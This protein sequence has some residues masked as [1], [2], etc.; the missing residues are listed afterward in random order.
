MKH[1]LYLQQIKE[2]ESERTSL[3]G[4]MKDDADK[5]ASTPTDTVPNFLSYMKDG[6]ENEMASPSILSDD[7]IQDHATQSINATND[8]ELKSDREALYGFTTEERNAWRSINSNNSNNHATMLRDIALARKQQEEEDKNNNILTTDSDGSIN[9][10][11]NTM[12]S[13]SFSHLTQDQRQIHMVDVGSKVPTRRTAVAQSLVTFPPEVLRALNKTEGTTST[14]EWIGP[15]GP[16]FATAITA[17]IM[18]VKQTSSL[19]PLCHP[20]PIEKI[21]IDIQWCTSDTIQIKCTC[22]VT[23]KTGVEMEALMGCSIAALTIYDMVKAISHNVL[24]TK[25]KLLYK[26]GGKRHVDER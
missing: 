8:D 4:T 20:L 17:G 26:D 18:G 24:I 2:L 6:A 15:K 1:Q 16:I 22:S 21:H 14:E 5:K 23:H 7:T 10:A 3:F 25:T 12:T 19:I 9:S 13:S 11:A